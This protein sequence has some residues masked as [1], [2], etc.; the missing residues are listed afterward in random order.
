MRPDIGVA[1]VIELMIDHRIGCVPGVD[2]RR[3][4]IG[5]ITKH[6]VVEQ[7]AAFMHARAHGVE[8]PGDIAARTADEL[9]LPLA[10]TIGHH[11]SL[12]IAATMM[13]V[14][15]IHHVLV[16]DD[17]SR[18]VGVVSSKDIVDRVAADRAETDAALA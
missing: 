3:R 2:D 15:G 18:L 16:V 4:P 1:T 12:A 8:L 14:E 9:M 6:D 5:V 13:A 17:D 10:L 7:L 11:G